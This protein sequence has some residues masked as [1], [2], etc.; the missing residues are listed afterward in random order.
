MNHSISKQ[1]ALCAVGCGVAL[2]LS[3]CLGS[4][5]SDGGGPGGGEATSHTI[6]GTVTGLGPGELVL[7]YNGQSVSISEDGDFSLDESIA[8]GSAF[9]ITVAEAPAEPSQTCDINPA[10]GE[11]SADVSIDITCVTP[12]SLQGRLST[13]ASGGAGTM[14]LTGDGAEVILTAG[15][16]TFSATVGN[17]GLYAFEV[18]LEDPWSMMRLDM[19]DGSAHFRSHVGSVV[20]LGERSVLPVSDAVNVMAET[21][22]GRVNLNHLNTAISGQLE[23]HH[24]GEEFADHAT[25][26]NVGRD[27]LTQDAATVAGALRMV[28]ENGEALPE[29]ADTTLDV[30]R[31]VPKALDWVE[32]IEASGTLAHYAPAS[33]L[34]APEQRSIRPASVTQSSSLGAS[35]AAALQDASV[36]D[37]GYTSLPEFMFATGGHAFGYYSYAAQFDFLGGQAWMR[38]TSGG[39]VNGPFNLTD[40]DVHIDFSAHPEPYIARTVICPDGDGGYE[41]CTVEYYYQDVMID[42]VMDGLNGDMVIREQTTLITYPD[43]DEVSDQVITDQIFVSLMVPGDNISL[44]SANVEGAIALPF[45]PERYMSLGQDSVWRQAADMVALESGG[46]GT[47]N[48]YEDPIVWEVRSQGELEIR[49]LGGTEIYKGWLFSGSDDGEGHILM[50]S[51]HSNEGGI[52]ADRAM[53]RDDGIFFTISDFHGRWTLWKDEELPHASFVVDYDSTTDP[54]ILYMGSPE[55]VAEMGWRFEAVG[56]P[57]NPVFELALCY[58]IDDSD[59]WEVVTT[60][61]PDMELPDHPEDAACDYMHVHRVWQVIREEDDRLYL[62]ERQT[63]HY[64]VG[65]YDIDDNWEGEWE[66]Q[67]EQDTIRYY[68]YDGDPEL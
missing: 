7:D 41:E 32:E 55:Q 60:T 45:P 66:L 4:S 26:A 59:G 67:M 58:G 2:S 50:N 5:G 68:G 21:V 62:V 1:M 46:S 64:P 33:D 8:A 39:I 51:H 22:T 16:Q 6:T 25:L 19:I 40:G 35:I 34:L 61:P 9:Q 28:T 14:S 44:D 65:G 47:L 49:P 42:R 3:A 30:A 12:V 13:A 17:D 36:N 52:V 63:R 20:G 57:A 23:W 37:G 10:S 18:A 11:V 31:D 48:F 43:S 54:H 15:D 27:L 53:R 24:G 29:W 56:E 38:E